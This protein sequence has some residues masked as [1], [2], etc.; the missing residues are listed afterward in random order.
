[1]R[2]YLKVALRYATYVVIFLAIAVVCTYGFWRLS[3]TTP[4]L[5]WKSTG[6]VV[7]LDYEIVEIRDR[8]FE[9][10]TLD[11]TLRF[12][13]SGYESIVSSVRKTEFYALDKPVRDVEDIL[14][15]E[16]ASGY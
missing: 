12:S 4:W 9:D 6:I 15:R 14:R 16:D 1:M 2:E 5:V 3:Y 11:R 7:S 8:G 10:L 13:E